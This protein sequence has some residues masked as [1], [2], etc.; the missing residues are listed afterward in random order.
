MSPTSCVPGP[1]AGSAPVE[2]PDQAPSSFSLRRVFTMMAG[3]D[4]SSIYRE[5]P[6]RATRVAGRGPARGGFARPVP[7]ILDFPVEFSKL[8]LSLPLELLPFR[9]G[10]IRYVAP[11]Q[12]HQQYWQK[13]LPILHPFHISILHISSLLPVLDY[14]CN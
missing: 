11:D 10:L 9:C 12:K 1:A 14:S 7:G 3:P 6:D 4:L 13:D 5:A 2:L 8:G